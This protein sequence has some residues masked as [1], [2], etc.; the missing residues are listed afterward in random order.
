MF[1]LAYNT[2]I[3]N[4]LVFEPLSFNKVYIDFD[5]RCYQVHNPISSWHWC[6]MRCNIFL[7]HSL[8]CILISFFFSSSSFSPYF[9]PPFFLFWHHHTDEIKQRVGIFR[10]VA[11]WWAGMAWRP[12]TTPI[13]DQQFAS[14]MIDW[15]IGKE[16]GN[17][18]LSMRFSHLLEISISLLS[19]DASSSREY[20]EFV[21]HV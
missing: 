9:F 18:L 13:G 14:S 15:V 1:W 2:F 20:D 3:R 4:D 12:C 7:P 17:I 5:T 16:E 8:F 21:V 11:G 19:C 6:Y 10:W